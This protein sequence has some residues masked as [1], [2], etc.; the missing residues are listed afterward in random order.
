MIRL[1]ADG[2][3]TR[4]VATPHMVWMGTGG[5]EKILTKLDLVREKVAE[6]GL[7]V[8]IVSGAELYLE[9]N[10]TDEV[11]SKRALT[12]NDGPYALVE[13]PIRDYPLYTD[14][15]LFEL[16][17]AGFTPIL[18]HPERLM[19]IL[20]DINLV[21]RLVQKGVLIQITADSL[22]GC[23]GPTIKTLTENMLRHNLVHIIASDA[24]SLNHRPPALRAAVERAAQIIEPARA[25]AMVTDLPQAII[26]G[27]PVSIPEPMEYKPHRVWG[28][29]RKA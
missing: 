15:I 7:S 2:G 22:L 14:Q 12:I 26:D 23:Y 20:K 8:D 1:A 6:A 19:P 16:R 25:W 27:Q 24:H 3:I 28:L 11:R 4:M 29:F 13:L 10:L 18:A 17:V 9:P 21:F 5:R